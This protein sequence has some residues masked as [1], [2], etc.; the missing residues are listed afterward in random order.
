MDDPSLGT[1]FLAE[2]VGTGILV[3]LGGGVVATALL[4]KSKG[5]D[6]GWLMINFG[7]GLGVFA[8]VSVA[9]ASGAHLNP[10]V[11]VGLLVTGE[12]DVVQFAVYVAAQLIG[13][14]LGACLVFLAYKQ[15]F[16]A[17]E[18]TTKKFSVFSTAPE[19]RSYRWNVVTETIATFVLVFVVIAFSRV[20]DTGSDA[21]AGLAA[22]GA[23]PVALLVVGIGASLGGP[24]GYAINPA[25]DL[26]PRIAHAVLPIKGKGT[27]DW[28]YAWVPILGPL[29]GGL[30]AGLA[31]YPLLPLLS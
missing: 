12:I 4:A 19:I 13:A 11:S 14:F 17:E 1:I 29:F 2:A 9:Y 5:L 30:L 8:G 28:A 22:L 26:G 7:W 20:G 3:L 6:G 31:S 27:S 18:D 16:D 24:T 23:M 10:A 25:R 15:H 21:P